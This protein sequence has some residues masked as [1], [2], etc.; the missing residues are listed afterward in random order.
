MRKESRQI[1]SLKKL[2]KTI[3]YPKYTVVFDVEFNACE[4]K[5]NVLKNKISVFACDSSCKEFLV[6]DSRLSHLMCRFDKIPM[7][8][9]DKKQDALRWFRS[10]GSDDGEVSDEEKPGVSTSTPTH[11]RDTDLE[12]TNVSEN[13]RQVASGKTINE[14]K[15]RYQGS[16][17]PIGIYVA[18]MHKSFD[19]LYIPLSPQEKLGFILRNTH[20][21]I[22][23]KLALVDI[24]SVEEL[25]NLV[26]R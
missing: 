24:G 1:L 9:V 6:L 23:D 11:V 17:E 26:V 18:I 25:L 14:I 19:R 13:V 8:N 12:S 16:N 10:D 4:D 20:T 15:S 3:V 7:T 21:F 22:Q 5:L 2:D